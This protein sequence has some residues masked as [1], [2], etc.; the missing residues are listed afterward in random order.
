[1]DMDELNAMI[2]SE[3]VRKFV[4]GTGY[5]FTDMQRA[6][7]LYHSDLPLEEKHSRL[8]ALRD[9]TADEGLRRQLTEYLDREK[10]AIQM[11]KENG[12]KRCVYVLKV[13]EN[14][15]SHDGEYLTCG[16]FF[17]WEVAFEYGKKEN[18]PFQIEKYLVNGVSEFEDGTCSHTSIADIH[19]DKN[20]NASFLSSREIP[21]DN[22]QTDWYNCFENTFYEVPNP[23]DRGDIV[24]L[25]GT[26]DYG[27]VEVSQ[28]RWKETLEKYKQRK[29]FNQTIPMSRSGSYFSARMGHSATV[30]L[31]PLVWSVMSLSMD[32]RTRLPTQ[33][34]VSLM[35]PV[36][37]TG[38]MIPAAVLALWTICISSPWSTGKQKDTIEWTLSY[39]TSFGRYI[40]PL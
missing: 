40:L 4:L 38:K 21:D 3:T 1:M 24:R 33:G 18:T 17:D 16:Y 23:F 6:A 30:I 7:L 25:V 13:Q 12:D 26:E 22:E 27:I 37:S 39:D 14:G 2:P 10:R 36:R 11:F 20:G 35:L 31:I 5:S 8:E 32:R 34:I 28:K 19:F 9:T 29:S 15:G